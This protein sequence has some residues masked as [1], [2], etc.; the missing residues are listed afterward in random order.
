MKNIIII[1]YRNREKHLNYFLLNSAPLLKKNIDNLQIII[2][3]QN[4]GKLFN[5]GMLLN[6]GYHYFNDPSIF[7]ITQDIDINPIHEKNN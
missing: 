6:I 7:Y 1:P 2:V 3:E 5:R 4:E